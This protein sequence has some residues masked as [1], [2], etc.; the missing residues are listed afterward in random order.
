MGGGETR[1]PLH[2]ERRSMRRKKL[3]ALADSIKRH[4]KYSPDEAFTDHQLRTLAE[5]LRSVNPRFKYQLWMDYIAGN[6][7]P[8]GGVIK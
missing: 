1:F 3:V 5:F 2:F 7:G 4:N 6:C 8:R